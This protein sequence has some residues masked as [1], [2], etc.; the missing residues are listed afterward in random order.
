LETSVTG[1]LTTGWDYSF[2]VLLLGALSATYACVAVS[3][4]NGRWNTW[5]LY[6][7][8]CLAVMSDSLQLIAC[9]YKK[10]QRFSAIAI[11]NNS[12]T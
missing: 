3:G 4:D 11:R 9:W 7:K 6:S 2:S 10:L 5:Y 8:F 12:C 1:F